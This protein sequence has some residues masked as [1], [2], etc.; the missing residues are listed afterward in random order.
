M[1][2]V[3]REYFPVIAPQRLVGLVDLPQGGYEPLIRQIG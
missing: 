1:E 3:G 2:N